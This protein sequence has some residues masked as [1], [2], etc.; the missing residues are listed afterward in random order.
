MVKRSFVC[1]YLVEIAFQFKNHATSW[2]MGNKQSVKSH[3]E[4]AQRTGVFQLQ[5]AKLIEVP[6][7]IFELKTLRSIDLSDNKIRE[8]P[9]QMEIFANL[10]TLLLNNNLLTSLPQQLCQLQRLEVLSLNENNI[11][12]LPLD[13]SN[14]RSL[15]VLNLSN[16]LLRTFPVQL[17]FLKQLDFIDLSNNK[18]N[19]VP[20][21][22][23]ELNV[24]ELNLNGNQISTLSDDLAKCPRL[25]V[26]RL[27]ENCLP[28][29]EL[30]RSILPSSNV[31]LLAVDGNLFDA[32]QLHD[33]P[34]YENY[35][36]RYT[37][38]KKKM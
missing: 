36:E 13:M 12:S 18:I 8:L 2:N 5:N 25:K 24:C 26:L 4:N 6:L 9:V 11:S 10:R 37:A 32:K 35:M 33:A 14:M 34:G 17:S 22:V 3:L 23:A 31:A 1:F 28:L 16:N 29:S 30:S 15:R 19:T 20:D 38:T 7:G 27:E 21:G